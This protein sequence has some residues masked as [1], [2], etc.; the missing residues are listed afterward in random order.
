MSKKKSVQKSSSSF[1]LD[2]LDAPA[3]LAAVN[4]AVAILSSIVETK[5]IIQ[6]GIEYRKNLQA[7]LDALQKQQEIRHADVDKLLSV[8]KD[9][10]VSQNIKDKYYLTILDLLSPTSTN[11]PPPNY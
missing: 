6:M 10:P 8:I 1:S 4:G 11:L 7:T 9:A 5:K 2:K 3:Q